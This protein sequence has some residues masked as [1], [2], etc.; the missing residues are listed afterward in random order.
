MKIFFYTN[1]YDTNTMLMKKSELR[2]VY[3]HV[4]MYVCIHVHIYIYMHVCMY[5]CMYVHVCI[6]THAYMYVLCTWCIYRKGTNFC[7]V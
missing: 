7:G 5:V 4:S 1:Y 2:Y 6:H 3:M